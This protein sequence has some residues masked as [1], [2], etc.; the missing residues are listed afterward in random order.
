MS[1][2]NQKIISVSR[3]TDIP[4]F[5][6]KWFATRLE[7]GFAEVVN[8]FNSKHIRTVSLLP[9]DVSA[10]VFWTRNARPFFANISRLVDGG[11]RFYFHWTLNNYPR[12]FEPRNPATERAIAS[13]HELAHRISAEKIIWRYDPILFSTETSMQW[14]V[15]NF[16]FLA[17]NLS[18]ATRR[19]IFSFVDLYKKTKRAL[20]KLDDDGI[21]I[22][23]AEEPEKR[24]LI[25]KLANISAQNRIQ[26]AACCEDALLSIDQ[27]E[28]ARCIDAHYVQ[29]IYPDLSVVPGRKA[30]RPQCG[31]SDSV[32]IGAYDSCLFGCVY[33]YANRDFSGR[34][35][36]R[37][38]SHNP[39][40]H[41]L[42]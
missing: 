28:K 23:E 39:K 26:L 31:C 17:E 36:K 37:F 6:S 42:I 8:P 14:H 40:N 25:K 12:I 27:V 16:Q 11:Y 33:C 10:F 1:K 9:N 24:N 2:C 13:F 21:F 15:E 22:Y 34:S 5:Y 41:R 4:A 18:G 29:N 35:R 19:C 7:E 32:D 20:E 30:T 3:S 38:Q